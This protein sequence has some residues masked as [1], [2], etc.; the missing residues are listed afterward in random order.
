[1]INCLQYSRLD[2]AVT[3][4]QKSFETKE[5]TNRLL[6]LV[7]KRNELI[8]ILDEENKFLETPPIPK[9]NLYRHSMLPNSDKNCAIQ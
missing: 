3:S 4:Q 6:Q 5:L 7:N 2:V 8:E 1:M 9:V